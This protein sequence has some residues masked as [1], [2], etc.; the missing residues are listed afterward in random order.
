MT[1]RQQLI[2]I[3]ALVDSSKGC[4][5]AYVQ[6]ELGLDDNMARGRLTRAVGLGFLAVDRSVKPHEY[7]AIKGWQQRSNFK[8][9]AC[10]AV[11]LAF[12][13]SGLI[14]HALRTQATSIF[15]LGAR[16]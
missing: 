11:R 7:S 13:E 9:P 6:T 16:L 14:R 1:P 2:R 12:P 3:C 15:N 4:S 8:R 5:A 10:R